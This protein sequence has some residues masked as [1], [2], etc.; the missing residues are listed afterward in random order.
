[1]KIRFGYVANAL[2]LFNASPSK[3]VTFKTYQSL[4]QTERRDKILNV[5]AQ[6]IMIQKGF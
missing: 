4:S 3:T 6:N 1:M 2:G 5:T